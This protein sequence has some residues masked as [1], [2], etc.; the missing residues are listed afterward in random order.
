MCVCV[1]VRVRILN[2]EFKEYEK[3]AGTS[4]R[5]YDISGR[6]NQS[7]YTNSYLL[8]FDHSGKLLN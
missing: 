8:G 2:L 1:C 5:P 7:H 4:T 6:S 3:F